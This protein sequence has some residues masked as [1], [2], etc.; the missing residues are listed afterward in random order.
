MRE[1]ANTMAQYNSGPQA[2]F[3][4][5]KMSELEKKLFEVV[6]KLNEKIDSYDKRFVLLGSDLSKMQSQVDLSMKLIHALQKEQVLLVQTM[7]M[8]EF[9]WNYYHAW[10]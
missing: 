9:K 2:R 7:N 8:S 6:H 1:L 10:G 3:L 5:T 4:V